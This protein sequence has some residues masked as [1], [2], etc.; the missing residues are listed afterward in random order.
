[1]AIDLHEDSIALDDEYDAPLKKHPKVR[2]EPFVG[3]APRRY[4]ALFSTVNPDGRRLRRK[5]KGGHVNKEPLGIR[6]K[7]SPLSS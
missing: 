2:F 6:H 3:I 4:A 1:M 7:A 5:V